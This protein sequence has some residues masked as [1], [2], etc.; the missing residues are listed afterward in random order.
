MQAEKRQFYS[1]LQHLHTLLDSH[2]NL[3]DLLTAKEGLH[4]LNES[5][6]RLQ[7][8][9]QLA[10]QLESCGEGL[11]PGNT[12]SE[13]CKRLSERVD[14][15]KTHL[16]EAIERFEGK[17]E[18]T[19]TVQQA[20]S[21]SATSDDC[22]TIEDT[23]VIQSEAS[24]EGVTCASHSKVENEAGRED[25]EVE[26]EETVYHSS[27]NSSATG[28]HVFSSSTSTTG[29][30]PSCMRAE[31]F[32]TVAA[33]GEGMGGSE[34]VKCVREDKTKGE[35]D[36][37]ERGGVSEACREP[38]QLELDL[39]ACLALLQPI[40]VLE[41][42]SQMEELAVALVDHQKLLSEVFVPASFS[43][44]EASK[45][46]QQ[47]SIQFKSITIFNFGQVTLVK[48][49]LAS[50]EKEVQ[51]LTNS[52]QQWREEVTRRQ[53][54]GE[55][56]AAPP[57]LICNFSLNRLAGFTCGCERLKYSCTPRTPPLATLQP[58]RL[59]SRSPMHYRTTSRPSSP[60]WTTSTRLERA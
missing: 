11:D 45:M 18:E 12:V 3:D 51:D 56:K 15:V 53:L 46:V 55:E 17:G 42:T 4:R 10:V 29:A 16:R 34:V 13:D 25:E 32:L 60:M 23:V 14:E 52:L 22:D 54:F 27:P 6:G 50:R 31:V 26:E 44:E 33:V 39:Q 8:V 24:E 1:L 48:E 36:K 37:K 9:K 7:E 35:E 43:E 19:F 28:L 5:E 20:E 41:D 59:R 21:S 58:L 38:C 57:S 30:G 49:K 47:V 40:L 2:S